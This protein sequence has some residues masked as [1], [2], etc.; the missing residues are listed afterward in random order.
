M[1][2]SLMAGKAEVRFEPDRIGASGVARLIE[3]LGFGATVLEQDAASQRRLELRVSGTLTPT[4]DP[5][6]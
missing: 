3:D 1:F 4:P 6:P 2:V 5:D